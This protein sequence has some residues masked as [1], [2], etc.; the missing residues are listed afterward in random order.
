VNAKFQAAIELFPEYMIT[1][2]ETPPV[3]INELKK[4]PKKGV[5][6]FYENGKPIYVG[7]SRNLSRRFNQHSRQNSNHNSATFAFKIAKQDAKNDGVLVKKTR[8][9]LQTDEKFVPYFDKAKHRVS[10]M[11]LQVKEI[12]DPVEQTLF[13][14]YASLE[15][16]TEYNN[17]DTH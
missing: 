8:N 14:V 10:N 6:V 2:L 9:K 1:L 4:I 11:M 7:R 13:E 17:W 15:L 3:P 16:K 12:S 5:Y